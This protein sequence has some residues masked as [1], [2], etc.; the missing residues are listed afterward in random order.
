[1]AGVLTILVASVLI[2]ALSSFHTAK[3][4]F[5]DI[6]RHDLDTALQLSE[7]MLATLTEDSVIWTDYLANGEP[8]IAQHLSANNDQAL[9]A[10]FDRHPMD[11]LPRIVLILDRNGKVVFR[12][13]SQK[14]KDDFMD[15][16]GIINTVL[17]E[18]R[19][20]P[21]ITTKFNHFILWNA[22]PLFYKNEVVGAVMAGNLID[23]QFIQKIKDGT[24]IDL[25]I[26][27]NQKVMASTLVGQNNTTITDL[28]IPSHEHQRL[29][30]KPKQ[31]MESQFLGRWHFV[32]TKP[33]KLTDSK[34]RGSI[35]LSKPRAELD[36]IKHAIF[37]ETLALIS[38]ALL[39]AVMAELWISRWLSRSINSLVEKAT[40]VADGKYDHFLKPESNTR[41][42]SRQDD[43]SSFAKNRDEIWVLMNCL[44]T[45]VQRIQQ[46][47]KELL[48]A[49]HE[50]ERT[51]E[52]RTHA[53]HT[54]EN[55][56]N[57]IYNS[58]PDGISAIDSNG[59]IL[60][61]NPAGLAMLE[62]DTLNE[63][64]GRCIYDLIESTQRDQFIK[65]NSLIFA[66]DSASLEFQ[67][68]TLKGNHIWIESSSVPLFDA[69]GDI[70]ENLSITRNITKRK[71]TGEEL[72]KL[73]TAVEQ[74]PANIII[75]DKNGDI[76]YVNPEFERATG[77]S[78]QSVIGKN[79]RLLK[80]GKMPPET[81]THLWETIT[82]GKVWR[83]ELQNKKKNGELYWVV[84]SICPVKN[85]EDEIT[86]FIAVNKDITLLKLREDELRAAKEAADA[87]NQT[88]SDFLANISHEIRTPMNAIIGLGHL[89]KKT[90]LTTEQ[91]DY[92]LLL[93]SASRK[94]SSLLNDLLDFS[95]IETK[96][97]TLQS[98]DFYVG[99][100]LEDITNLAN[101][102]AKEKEIEFKLSI[103]DDIPTVLVGDSLRLSQV[104]NNLVSNAMEF[105]KQGE[106]T[107]SAK[108]LKR[109]K[110]KVQLQFAVKDT[111]IG[112]ASEQQ[113]KLFQPFTQADG[114]L[115]RQHGGT[116]LGLT[117]SRKLVEMMSGEIWLES[118]PGKGSTFTF[119]A[120]FGLGADLCKA[121]F[122][123]SK[124]QTSPPPPQLEGIQVLLVE[125]DEL[126]QV[127]AQKLLELYGIHVTLA[128]NGLEA[129]EAVNHQSF[130][131][132]LMDI[133]MPKLDGYQATA[134]IR[135]DTQFKDLP[136]VAM[137]AHAMA[138]EREKCLAAGMDDHLSK[139]FKV[140]QLKQLL[141]KWISSKR[142]STPN[143][144]EATERDLQESSE[145]EIRD[146]LERLVAYMGE[147]SALTPL[148]TVLNLLPGRLE[149]LT[150]ALT[151]SDWETTKRQAHSLKGSLNVYGSK[152]LAKLLAQI[153]KKDDLHLEAANLAQELETE[154][155]LAL[156]LV[157]EVRDKI[158]TSH[159]EADEVN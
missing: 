6:V 80:S 94:Q 121:D 27:H 139:P 52:E 23:S 145:T 87:A 64:K 47:E 61:V 131:L 78:K 40:L 75:T 143:A 55:R 127:V 130:D 17:T 154:L 100:V 11:A 126:N 2:C 85:D 8:E 110:D 96:Q 113:Q 67:I 10:F 70:T 152:R 95:N 150:T 146:N 73:F 136:I 54:T 137:T 63:A 33:L 106:I 116:G 115:T 83:G 53:L 34:F 105:T 84:A 76:E 125:D 90:Q 22:A 122:Q 91:R 29:L 99:Y 88:K 25:T 133:Q 18:D 12:N 46:R 69:H 60:D 4:A 119:T 16:P 21:V 81:Y 20:G 74:G 28:P 1:M 82:K 144:V 114:S 19:V 44:K 24:S 72:R 41:G 120:E 153:E 147:E 45:L 92:L 49:H 149:K 128:K 134:A 129:V 157:Q 109:D 159:P 103:S 104:L 158:A 141:T 66:G 36:T 138:N 15:H 107:I 111:G 71:K 9:A 98:S 13:H 97:L 142:L 101:F 135:K 140:A 5:N 68:Q 117:I 123:I 86:H 39:L 124:A 38:L 93:Q 43:A 65:I 59:T 37:Q 77:H 62:A 30:A 51:V 35:L 148:D 50:L 32:T 156:R 112:I 89:L 108:V 58:N 3:K 102:L 118:K 132:V 31:V 151:T 26:V 14:L 56:L 7:N 155:S 57:T 48:Q 79:P 42:I